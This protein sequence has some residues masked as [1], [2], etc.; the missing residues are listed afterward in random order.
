MA[1]DSTLEPS[2]ILIPFSQGSFVRFLNLSLNCAERRDVYSR[3]YLC[4]Y[5]FYKQI[6]RV[7]S[8]LKNYHTIPAEERRR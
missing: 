2:K 4:H 7:K 8:K 1:G 5:Y 3:A 6:N